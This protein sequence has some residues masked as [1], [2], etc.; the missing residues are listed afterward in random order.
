MIKFITGEPALV[1]N[2]NLVV[3]DLHIGIETEYRKSGITIPTQLEKIKEKIDGLIKKSKA[4]RLIIIG[5]V[6]HQVPGVSFQE[7]REVPEFFNYFS[8]KIETHIV[9]GNHDSEIPALVEKIKI[10]DTMGLG[11]VM[12]IWPM[13]T[14][15]P[16]RNSFLANI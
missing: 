9:L 14:L 15:G 6:K 2:K 13:A 8:G 7:L 10:H 11:W 12:C 4:R 1:F 3:A 5:D 16:K